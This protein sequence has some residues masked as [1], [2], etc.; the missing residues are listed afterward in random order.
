MN[1]WVIQVKDFH[2]TYGL[3]VKKQGELGRMD[4]EEMKALMELRSRLI[5]EE[6]NETVKAMADYVKLTEENKLD[7][8]KDAHKEILDGIGDTIVVSVGAAL[9]LGIDIE[10]VMKRIYAS[11][12]SKL[13]EDG[14]PIYREDGK[15]LKGPNFFNPNLVDLI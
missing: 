9:A 6:A 7:E 10:E 4:F 8:R 3:P 1:E 15:V 13:G 14:K 2:E 5:K 12:M 11:N